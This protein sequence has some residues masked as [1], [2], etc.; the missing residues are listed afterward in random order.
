[1]F[2]NL[3]E[4]LNLHRELNKTLTD[5]KERD[6]H[7]VKTIGDSLLLRVFLNFFSIEIV[8]KHSRFDII[9]LLI[10]AYF[11]AFFPVFIID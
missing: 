5:L 11:D 10:L 9:L 4:I 6:G 1:M 7:V 2:P 8:C 3:K